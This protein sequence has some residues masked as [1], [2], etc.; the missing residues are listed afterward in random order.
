MYVKPKVPEIIQVAS[1]STTLKRHAIADLLDKIF[2]KLLRK[3]FLDMLDLLL[4]A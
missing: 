4:I 2:L 3:S 1:V